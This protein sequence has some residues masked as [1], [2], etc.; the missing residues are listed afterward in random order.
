VLWCPGR[1]KES[2]AA[3]AEAISLLEPLP[4]G[5]ELSKAYAKMAMT[6]AAAARDEEAVVWAK[7]SL[8]IAEN[9]DDTE[10]SFYA[11]AYLATCEPEDEGFERF[12]QTLGGAQRAGCA[13]AVGRVVSSL[14]GRAVRT[15]R[16][17]VAARHLDLGLEYCGAHGLELSHLYLLADRARLELAQGRWSRAAETAALVLGVPRT[18][19]TPRIMAL[20]VLGLVRARRGDPGHRPLLDEAWALAEPTE[21]LPRLGFVAVARAEA[22][23]LAGDPQAVA[24]AIQAALPLALELRAG[25]FVGELAQW[26]RRVDLRG[27]SPQGSCG[28]YRLQ[29]AGEWERAS[30]LWTEMGCPYEAALALMDSDE[31]EPLRRALDAL[32][33]LEARPAAAIVARRLRE[34][35]ARSLPRGPRPATRKNQFG[36]TRR[37][38]DV[39]AL[40]NAG[41]QNGQIADQLVVSVRTV[42]H[43]VEAILRKLGART[44]SD[45]Q[46]AAKVLGLMGPNR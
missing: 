42:D 27:G 40:V 41:L 13:E 12:E 19:T 18:S 33:R 21:E 7:R 23:W 46:A 26:C 32:Q 44:R 6:C 35:G 31:E 29:L 22:G 11:T 39:L 34:R 8:E 25:W 4:P 14:V 28:P 15:C 30:A 17:E 45:T 43:H 24:S 36:L 10:T 3:A 9:L 37:E 1:T 2:A 16:Y 5:R 38:L 20:V